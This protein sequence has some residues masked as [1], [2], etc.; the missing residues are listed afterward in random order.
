MPRLSLPLRQPA[1]A[2]VVVVGYLVLSLLAFGVGRAAAGNIGLIYG[3]MA[4]SAGLLAVALLAPVP[5]GRTD[6]PDARPVLRR[7]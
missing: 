1:R 6:D 4:A 7:G 3:G 2:L 5:K